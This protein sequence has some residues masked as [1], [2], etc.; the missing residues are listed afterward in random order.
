MRNEL[1][2]REKDIGQ[3]LSE[4][5]LADMEEELRK[6]RKQLRDES[7]ASVTHLPRDFTAKAPTLHELQTVKSK[8]ERSELTLAERMRDLHNCETR[9]KCAEEQVRGWLG[10]FGGQKELF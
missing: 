3:L 6:L 7:T 4:S 8:M 5:D 10:N 9:L 2:K 1:E